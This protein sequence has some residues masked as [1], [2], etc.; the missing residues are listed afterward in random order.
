MKTIILPLTILI[1]LLATTTLT[2]Q[3]TLPAPRCEFASSYL[4]SSWYI[5][6]G[7]VDTTQ[8]KSTETM[9]VPKNDLHEWAEGNDGW[10]E[11]ADINPPPPRNNHKM[12]AINGKLYTF[13][14]ESTDPDNY[15][16]DLWEY[17][18]VSKIWTDKTQTAMG[19]PPSPGN[20]AKYG[21]A[22]HNNKMYLYGGRYRFTSGSTV[23]EGVSHSINSY[24]PA[25][26]Y[27]E[28]IYANGTEPKRYDAAVETYNGKMYVWGGKDEN[29]NRT[30]TIWEYDLNTNYWTDITPTT[31]AMPPP[32]S[33]ANS[34]LATIN[35]D[36]GMLI[37]GG[38]SSSTNTTFAIKLWFLKF[39]TTQN[40][41]VKLSTDWEGSENGLKMQGFALAPNSKTAGDT[42]IL[43]IFGGRDSLWHVNN[44]FMRYVFDTTF[45]D[46]YEYDTLNTQWVP[47]GT[48]GILQT[49]IIPK[50]K[51]YPNPANDILNIEFKSK[52]S[53]VFIVSLFNINGQ[54]IDRK[55]LKGTTVK[56]TFNTKRIDNGVYMITISSDN[57]LLF[58]NKIIKFS[59][60]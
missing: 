16:Q 4:D 14:G 47:E 2:A 15:L 41:V 59:G 24:N 40:K 51:V 27:W 57:K 37:F 23:Y 25:T 34:T 49:Q 55:M 50:V 8:N 33:G 32:F 17:D 18:P 56:T 44:H 3:D 46:A 21:L 10:L 13:G 30:N 42:C 43:S 6:G 38:K 31:G 29:N 12:V 19:S 39:N 7:L 54:L 60:K 1:A 53:K 45:C 22:E 58:R 52:Q 5:F 26:N 9:G 36:E 11:L 20:L 28:Y 35:Q 48:V